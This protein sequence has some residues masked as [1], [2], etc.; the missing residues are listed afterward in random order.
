MLS[1]K[2]L[3]LDIVHGREILLCFAKVIIFPIIGGFVIQSVTYF[4]ANSLLPGQMLFVE[5]V[6]F[7]AK[8][9]DYI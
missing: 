3:H 8:I 6:H 9:F 4:M 7:N 5:C 1:I 2:S